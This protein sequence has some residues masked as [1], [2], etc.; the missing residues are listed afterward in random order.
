MSDGS[1]G[2]S[3][4]LVREEESIGDGNNV[5]LDLF[6]ERWLRWSRAVFAVAQGKEENDSSFRGRILQEA[7]SVTDEYRLLSMIVIENAK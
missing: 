1:I 7:L 6:S 2:I 3:D 5:S 4:V